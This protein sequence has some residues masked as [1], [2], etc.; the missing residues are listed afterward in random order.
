VGVFRREGR[1]E[2]EA[3]EAGGR[4]DSGVDMHDVV[5]EVG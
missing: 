3:M 1:G 5:L 4:V 2:K